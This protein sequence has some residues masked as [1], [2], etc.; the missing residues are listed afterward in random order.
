LEDQHMQPENLTRY[1][2]Q[3]SLHGQTPSQTLGP[4]FAQGLLRSDA[5]S[6]QGPRAPHAVMG[7]NPSVPA[8]VLEGQVWDGLGRPVLDALIELWQ[9][10]EAGRYQHPLDPH[11][12]EVARNFTGFGRTASDPHGGFRFR[13]VRPGPV[14]TASGIVSASHFCL[15]LG[16]R[17]LSRLLYTRVYFAGDPLLE[18]DPVWNCVPADRRSTLLCSATPA[19]GSELRYHFDIQLQGPR[20]TVFF[21][22]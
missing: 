15:I 13:T 16:A 6:G 22:V 12:A 19:V 14:T 7:A 9:A 21:D 5:E 8:L 4:Y 20:E 3:Y 18:K 2:G 10:D 1:F 17:G 11:A